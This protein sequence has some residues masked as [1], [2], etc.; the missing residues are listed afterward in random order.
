[1]KNFDLPVSLSC[2]FTAFLDIRLHWITLL[3][4]YITIF[5]ENIPI[6]F[7]LDPVP[8]EFIAALCR[9]VVV[10]FAN[11]RHLPGYLLDES[12]TPPQTAIRE[13]RNW[14]YSSVSQLRMWRTYCSSAT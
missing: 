14:L 2:F 4:D 7:N 3:L 11:T 13:V 8:P 9:K 6:L 10:S 1:M 5:R 12:N